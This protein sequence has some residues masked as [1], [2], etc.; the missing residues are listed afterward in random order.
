MQ[1]A[2]AV[3]EAA[4]PQGDIEQLVADLWLEQLGRPVG[5][6]DNFFDIGGHSLLAVSLFRRLQDSTGLAIALTDVFR[7]PDSVD[8][9]RL[10]AHPDR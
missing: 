10:P 8:V 6:T 4:A 3:P 7:Y 1:A 5:R 9:R 2:E